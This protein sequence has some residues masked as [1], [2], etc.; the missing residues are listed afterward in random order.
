MEV[1]AG[2]CD[3]GPSW[4]EVS[5]QSTGGGTALLVSLMVLGTSSERRRLVR[6]LCPAY[7][8]TGLQGLHRGAALELLHLV[9]ATLRMPGGA[10]WGEKWPASHCCTRASAVDAIV[11]GPPMW[12]RTTEQSDRFRW[13]VVHDDILVEVQ[14]VVHPSGGFERVQGAAGSSSSSSS[15]GSSSGGRG[16]ASMGGGGTMIQSSSR[17]RLTAEQL[18]VVDTNVAKA[19][20][21]KIV[22]YA[23]TGKTTVLLE[24]A[25]ARPSKKYLYLAFNTSV[26][27]EAKRE[28]SSFVRDQ[29]RE[30]TS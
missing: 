19:E 18:A 2:R 15:K 17:S 12:R 27:D 21:L 6:A 11:H 8:A 20:I 16:I 26:R 25:R 3:E 4:I 9:L 1:G 28:L 13:R 29:R 24:Y 30:T 22:A 10:W 7:G 5:Q 23:G 14:R